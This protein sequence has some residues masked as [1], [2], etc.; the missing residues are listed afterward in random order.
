MPQSNIH[1]VIIE[2]GDTSITIDGKTLANFQS[3]GDMAI[4]IA[5]TAME[6]ARLE[7][8]IRNHASYL[9]SRTPDQMQCL[10]GV[11]LV[12]ELRTEVSV[13]SRNKGAIRHE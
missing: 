8:V 9:C 4:A 10:D 1:I 2:D 5:C 13:E 7:Q 3:T 6:C 12:A 11:K